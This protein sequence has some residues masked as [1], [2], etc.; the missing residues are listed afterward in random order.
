[1]SD[2]TN[3]GGDVEQIAEIMSGL[4]AVLDAEKIVVKLHGGREIVGPVLGFSL[5]RKDR[6]G[7]VTW[8]GSVRVQIEPGEL[9]IDCMTIDSVA[10]K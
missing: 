10:T 3:G 9:E 4:A 6:K 8:S 2:D 7:E 5:K 1:M